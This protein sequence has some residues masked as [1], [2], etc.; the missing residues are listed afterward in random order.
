MKFKQ[1]KDYTV[2][3]RIN[4]EGKNAYEIVAEPLGGWQMAR[5][6]FNRVCLN[7]WSCTAQAWPVRWWNCSPILLS[8]QG[9]GKR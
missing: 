1:S 7:Q 9:C 3:S 6:M 5:G 8:A 2:Y 4:S